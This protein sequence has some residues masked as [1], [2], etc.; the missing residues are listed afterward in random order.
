[1]YIEFNCR[2]LAFDVYFDLLTP[3]DDVFYTPCGH[4]F[5]FVCVTQWLERSKSCP[6]CRE[7]TT[8][9]QIHRIYFS[10]SN[11]DTIVEDKYSLQDK[12]DKLTLQ[13]TMKEKDA[14][15]YSE[16]YHAL[17]K[18]TTHLKE[19]L[20]KTETEKNS[21]IDALKQQLI[22]FK[23]QA[24][25]TDYMQKEN[26]QLKKKVET[27]KNI[28]TLLESSSEEVD[29]LISRS[30]DPNTLI[31]YISVMKREMT[32]SL[33]R[34]RELR[35][36]VKS[37]QQDLTKV[38]MERN[39]LSEEHTKRKKIEE[40]LITCE[41]EKM[42]LQNKLRD[43]EKNGS[44]SSKSCNCDLKMKNSENSN[45]ENMIKPNDIGSTATNKNTKIED[46]SEK[47]QNPTADTANH[48]END[49]PY[50]P[51]KSGGVFVLKQLTTKKRSTMKSNPSILIKKPRIEQTNLT[52]Y[53]ISFNGFGGHSKFNQFPGTSGTTEGIFG[54]RI[55]ALNDVVL[56]SISVR[57]GDVF[58]AFNSYNALFR[59]PE[60]D[61][62]L[63]RQVTSESCTSARAFSSVTLLRGPNFLTDFNCYLLFINSY[64]NSNAIFTMFA[65][66]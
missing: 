22:Y 37:L 64:K 51:V 53:P 41:S 24:S 63:W 46:I 19:V 28:Q 33:S 34:R 35:S 10:F 54:Q 32:I 62:V 12:V 26:E 2:M 23:E 36:K 1:M 17:K 27:Y 15:H 43:L 9:R 59:C 44:L 52:E 8:M 49:S 38:S 60:F 16:K 48:N 30:C 47:E 29:Q 11:N 6:Q 50:L 5:H 3:S 7:K 14:K 45:S 20:V 57:N 61:P 4:I 58:V 42:L 13:L 21:I 56:D 18:E 40:D 25:K 55:E 66:S 65:H 31:T 39:F